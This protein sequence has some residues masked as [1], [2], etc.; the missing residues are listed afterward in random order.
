MNALRAVFA[1]AL[2]CT[3]ARP[4]AA[5]G[6]ALELVPMIGVRGGVTMDPDQPGFAPAEA[7]P[8][9]SFGLGLDVYLRP[10]AWFE[11]FIE[12]QTL[13][14]TADPDV[15]GVSGFDMNI[16]YLQFGG[17]YEPREGRVRPFVSAA[18]GLTRYGA[19]V[20]TVD[21]AVGLSG[22]VGGGFKAAMGERLAFKLEVLGYATVNAA[23]LSVS[24]GAGCFVQFSSS[25]WYQLAARAGLAIRL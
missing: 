7:S 9:I 23:A 14:F 15:F 2:A 6:H 25:G 4:A 3:V 20:G 24:C 22:S 13:S 8:A 19:D 12:R 21:K 11:A 1:F 18:L 16:D 17:G 5:G 10:D